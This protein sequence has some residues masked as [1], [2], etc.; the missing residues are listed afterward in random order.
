M[1]EPDNDERGFR[2]A[3]QFDLPLG[4]GSHH[5]HSRVRNNARRENGELD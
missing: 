3:A 2:Q 5:Y 1:M 4:S